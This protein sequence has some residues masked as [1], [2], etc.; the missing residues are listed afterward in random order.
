MALNRF[1]VFF[2]VNFLCFQFTT[3]NIKWGV[4]PPEQSAGVAPMK[5]D[6]ANMTFPLSRQNLALGNV[7]AFVRRVYISIPTNDAL[8]FIA[9]GPGDSGISLNAAAFGFVSFNNALTGYTFDQRGTGLSSPVKACNNPT[10]NPST[11]YNP[12]NPSSVSEFQG[13]ILNLKTNY[14]TTFQYYSTY[15]A[16]MDFLGFVQAVNPTT[17]NLY[18]M[19]YGSYFANTYMMLPGARADCIV[20][21]GPVPSNRWPLENNA[22]W[23]SQVAQDIILTC[24]SNSSVCAGFV[25]DMGHIPKLVNDAIIDGTLPCSSKLSWLNATTPGSA[26][27]WTQIM[28]VYLEQGTNQPGL[29]PFWYRLFRCSATDVVQL[30]FLYNKVSMV[31][32]PESSVRYSM[33]I[34]III[35]TSELYSYAGPNA[36]TYQQQLVVGPR[37]LASAMTNYLVAYA[38]S[39]GFPVYTPNSLYFKKFFTPTCPVLIFVGTFDSNT[40]NGLGT[41]YQTALNVN[42]APGKGLVTLLNVPYTCHITNDPTTAAGYCAIGISANWWASTGKST[43][44]IVCL[45]QIPIPDWDGSSSEMQAFSNATFNTPYIWNSGNVKDV[46][47]PTC[48]CAPCAPTTMPTT[49]PTTL[50]APCSNANNAGNINNQN[51]VLTATLVPTLVVI[52]ILLGYIF[53]LRQSLS[54]RQMSRQEEN[55]KL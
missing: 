34:A 28:S 6:C 45:S 4:C 7:T 48:T 35:G 10:G 44:S 5:I 51:T 29:A 32:S 23:N 40:E 27:Y 38:I 50:C 54:S 14:A 31:S 22:E 2:L 33:G 37:N 9:G 1:L 26:T 49:M 20:L 43:G 25:G 12:F 53:V 39:I 13:C 55:S 30:N 15:D 11:A 46:P 8:F 24:A 42:A 21:D 19:S 52:C 16:A 36:L 41:W 3:A 17:M 47:A 18:A